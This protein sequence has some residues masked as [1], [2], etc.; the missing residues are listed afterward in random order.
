LR[1]TRWFRQN[2]W[3]NQNLSSAPSRQRLVE[4][5]IL[6]YILEVL[7]LSP[8]DQDTDCFSDEPGV[9]IPK[10]AARRD[11]VHGGMNRLRG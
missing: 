4:A 7:M 11:A 6:D 10:Q 5:S 1:R 9:V 8:G 3:E 2:I